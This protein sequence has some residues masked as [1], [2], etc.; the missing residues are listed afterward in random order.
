MS[1]NGWKW[2]NTVAWKILFTKG[3][4]STILQ[5]S[6]VQVHDHGTVKDNYVRGIAWEIYQSIISQL[7]QSLFTRYDLIAVVKLFQG[8]MFGDSM[9]WNFQHC[10]SHF[11]FSF[12]FRDCPI[13]SICCIFWISIP[14]TF[15]KNSG[16]ACEKKPI[17]FSRFR[18]QNQQNFV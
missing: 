14:I 8:S 10:K 15:Y 5:R 16:R 6:V 2:Q 11:K 3:L 7:Q 13:H 12:H 1:I 18:I 9:T 4:T 17:K